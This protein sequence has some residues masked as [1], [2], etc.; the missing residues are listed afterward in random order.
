MI[1]IAQITLDYFAIGNH[2]YFAEYVISPQ[3]KKSM[4]QKQRQE[5]RHCLFQLPCSI[6]TK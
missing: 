4:V 6:Y 2:S 1:H 5:Q 3:M